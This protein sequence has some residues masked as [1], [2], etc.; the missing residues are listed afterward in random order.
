M[1]PTT[2]FPNHSQIEPDQ[3]RK[4]PKSS[5]HAY[6][7]LGKKVATAFQ[8]GSDQAFQNRSK[9]DD[10]RSCLY[11]VVTIY[12][13]TC[14]NLIDSVFLAYSFGV[15]GALCSPVFGIGASVGLLGILRKTPAMLIWSWTNLLLFNLHNQR[16][17]KAILEDAIN[18]AWRPLPAKRI[19]AAE[20]TY[21]MYAMYPIVILSSMCSGGLVP[22]LVEMFCC[23][24]HNE[25]RGDE[26]PFFKNF[27]NAVGIACLLAGP[28]EILVLGSGNSL[29]R[30]PCVI[31]WL[32]LI[33][34]A[35]LTTVHTQD[36]RDVDGDKLRGRRTIPLAIGDAPA[37]WIVVIGVLLFSYLAPAFW[38]LGV[39]GFLLPASTGSVMV[40]N[41][42]WKRT[43]KGDV[44]T[45]KLWPLWITSLFFLP[46][47]K[48]RSGSGI[49]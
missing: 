40:F 35:V 7:T 29:F 1:E 41:L 23:I 21:V 19:T 42:L 14:N 34:F 26:S 20:T 24:W 28:L 15:I 49:V 36:F 45:W 3:A 27:L 30:H 4:E 37:R 39:A 5:K 47:I 11:H 12:L 16:H 17:P 2:F 43:Y 31:Q 10:S 38:Q 6:W 25:W 48:M 18:K 8:H 32:A 13:F 33:A 22:C 9:P 46:L 44:L